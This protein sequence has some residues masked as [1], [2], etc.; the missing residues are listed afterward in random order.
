MAHLHGAIQKI[1]QKCPVVVEAVQCIGSEIVVVL[2][3]DPKIVVN[4]VG[5]I[6]AFN[7]FVPQ[8]VIVVQAIND[9]LAEIAVTVENAIELDRKIPIVHN[10]RH[11]FHSKIIVAVN[12]IRESILI[13]LRPKKGLEIKIGI[14]VA[15]RNE[16]PIGAENNKVYKAIPVEIPLV[17][18]SV[19]HAALRK[20]AVLVAVCYVL[21]RLIVSLGHHLGSHIRE[22]PPESVVRY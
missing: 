3:I 16:C 1:L 15:D 17:E 8:F 13:G 4:Q 18:K 20:I 14:P 9:F 12:H 10:S 11:E 7:H 19:N 21:L 6:Q 2:K 5:K 22:I